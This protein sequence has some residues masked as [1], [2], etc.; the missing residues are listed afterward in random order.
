[1]TDDKRAEIR[2]RIQK[3]QSDIDNAL[4][5]IQALECEIDRLNEKLKS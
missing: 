5:D 2:E 1:M 3:I 4:C